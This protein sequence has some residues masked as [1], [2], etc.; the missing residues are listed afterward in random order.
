MNKPIKIAT[1]TTNTF[2]QLPKNSRQLQ[3]D[4]PYLQEMESYARFANDMNGKDIVD[5]LQYNLP[6]DC[7]CG[8]GVFGLKKDVTPVFNTVKA[9][10]L[11]SIDEPGYEEDLMDVSNVTRLTLYGVPNSD[12]QIIMGAGYYQG[13]T[14]E[15]EEILKTSPN[16]YALE[17][18]ANYSDDCSPPEDFVAAATEDKDF[19]MMLKP[20]AA[21]I[22]KSLREV[23]GG[24][25]S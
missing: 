2:W 23:H 3:G 4:Y 17:S 22:E 12:F 10:M 16:V 11:S 9:L 15:L 13:S 8:F 21:Y 20:L 5:E 25:H 7:F 24:K 18:G 19:P 14:P 6:W 1:G